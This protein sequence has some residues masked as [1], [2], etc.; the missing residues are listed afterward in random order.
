MAR[1]FHQVVP[2]NT[3]TRFNELD[4]VAVSSA[5]SPGGGLPAVDRR[6]TNLM[7]VMSNNVHEDMISATGECQVCKAVEII[8]AATRKALRSV[9]YFLQRDHF[10]HK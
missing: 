8:H 9:D 4:G 1:S 2:R 7:K 3:R 5:L 6:K 10:H